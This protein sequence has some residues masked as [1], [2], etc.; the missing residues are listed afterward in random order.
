[1]SFNRYLAAPAM[2]TQACSPT[3]A[4]LLTKRDPGKKAAPDFEEYKISWRITKPY[5]Q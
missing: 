3:R 5:L 4:P 2:L 1:M